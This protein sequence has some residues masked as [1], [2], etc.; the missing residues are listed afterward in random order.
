MGCLNCNTELKHTPGKRK[1]QFCSPDCRVRY[2][3][4]NKPKKE[5][6]V[7]PLSDFID[8]RKEQDAFYIKRSWNVSDLLGK[9]E[10]LERDKTYLSNQLGEFIANSSHVTFKKDM[11]PHEILETFGVEAYNKAITAAKPYDGIMQGARMPIMDDLP[12]ASEPLADF[13]ARLKANAGKSAEKRLNAT[14][15]EEIAKDGPKKKPAELSPFL[16]SRQNLKNGIK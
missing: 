4:K 6:V 15:V 11:T 9:I 1:K 8:V 14:T 16:K 3:Q 5:M 2:W 13:K 10:L 12:A 7:D